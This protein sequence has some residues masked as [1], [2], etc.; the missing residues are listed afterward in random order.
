[1][2]GV[3]HMALIAALVPPSGNINLTYRAESWNSSANSATPSFSSLTIGDAS[4]TRLVIVGVVWAIS[5]ATNLNSATIGGVSATVIAQNDGANCGTAVIMAAVPSGTTATVALTFAN[6]V[7]RA[8]VVVWTL[9]GHISSTPHDFDNPAGGAQA[10]RTATLDIPAGGAAVAIAY[11]GADPAWTS[12]TERIFDTEM[13]GADT[14][15]AGAGTVIQCASCRAIC[16][17]SW[18]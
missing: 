7:P 16:A 10:I 11:S 12:A 8:G 18:S 5:G 9:D 15:T 1:M 4:A 14:T 17:V 3:S 13:S 6:S 2:A